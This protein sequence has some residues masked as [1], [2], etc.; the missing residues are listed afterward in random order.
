MMQDQSDAA[1]LVLHHSSFMG[2]EVHRSL[3]EK[4]VKEKIDTQKSLN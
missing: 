2:G 3:K 4:Q 1:R